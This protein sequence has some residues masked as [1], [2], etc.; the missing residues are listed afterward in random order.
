MLHE[1][2]LKNYRKS[3]GKGSSLYFFPEQ[4]RWIGAHHIVRQTGL[5]QEEFYTRITGLNGSCEICGSKCKFEKLSKGFSRFCSQTCRST[6]MWSIDSG[7]CL[8]AVSLNGMNR[9]EMMWDDQDFIYKKNLGQ[10]NGFKQLTLY[11][12]EG[13]EFIKF[14]ITSEPEFRI[15]YLEDEF[16]CKLVGSVLLDSDEA[17][18]LEA[19]AHTI[20]QPFDKYEFR[21]GKRELRKK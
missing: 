8:A 7:K 2:F 18:R 5:T 20:G 14:G 3:E 19:M 15:S 4:D 10:F 6:N 16:S 17:C 21:D 13:K 12:L 11:I 9:S 1:E